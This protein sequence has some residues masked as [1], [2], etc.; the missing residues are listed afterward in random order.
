MRVYSSKSPLYLEA[1]LGDIWLKQPAKTRE[2]NGASWRHGRRMGERNALSAIGT[3][4]RVIAVVR[5][6]SIGRQ[7]PD[8]PAGIR[9]GDNDEA[10]RRRGPSRTGGGEAGGRGGREA[11]AVFGRHMIAANAVGRSFARVG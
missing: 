8:A 5:G 1:L 4:G 6:K 10:F 9:K 7:N 2:K 11:I 3:N